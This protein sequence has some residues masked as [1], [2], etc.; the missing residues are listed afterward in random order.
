V[1]AWAADPKV[2]LLALAVL[3]EGDAALNAD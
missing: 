1:R 2:E 3:A